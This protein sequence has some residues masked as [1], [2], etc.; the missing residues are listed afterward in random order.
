MLEPLSVETGLQAGIIR[1]ELEKLGTSIGHYDYLIAAHALELGA[2]LVT[3]NIKE[4]KRVKGLKLEN[5]FE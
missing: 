4:F 1:S 2:T 5:W 3:N